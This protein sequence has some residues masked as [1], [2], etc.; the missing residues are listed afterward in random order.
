MTI[1]RFLDSCRQVLYR[2]KCLPTVAFW[3]TTMLS[4]CKINNNN[5]TNMP[6]R[7]T[8]TIELTASTGSRSKRYLVVAHQAMFLLKVLHHIKKTIR[9]ATQWQDFNTSKQPAGYSHPSVS[10]TNKLRHEM[11]PPTISSLSRKSLR[12]FKQMLI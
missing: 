9:R 1:Q 7:R 11:E 2:F 12:D 4:N 5:H 3:R 10:S 8:L 6:L